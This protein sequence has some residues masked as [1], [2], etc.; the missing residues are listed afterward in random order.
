MGRP[1]DGPGQENLRRIIQASEK[2]D[3]LIQDLLSYSRLSR[4]GVPLEPAEL[5][6]V[7]DGVLEQLSVEVQARRAEIAI[8]QSWCLTTSEAQSVQLAASLEYLEVALVGA[9]R[10]SHHPRRRRA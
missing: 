3:T 8:D 1:L 10:A 9:P 4:E 5:G 7:L 2:M 6:Q